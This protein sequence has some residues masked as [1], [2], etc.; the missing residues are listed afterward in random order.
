M[1]TR[2]TTSHWGAFE[3]RVKDGRIV[4]TAPFKDD[5][6]PPT[7][8]RT[9][10]QA[11]HH[12]TR[13]NRPHVR[14]GWLEKDR[15]KSRS[16]DTFIPM[17]WDEALDLAAQEIDRVRTQHG[18]T[19]I[20]GGSYG[21][22]SAGRFHHA[23][24]QVHRF[25][26]LLGG[27]VSSFAS[28]STGAAQTII[29]HILGTNF[30]K[31]T[32]G[33]QSTWDMIEAHT[34]TLLMFGGINPK[35]AQVSMGGVTEH[36]TASH[37][38]RFAA[39][40]K[41][42]IS[43]S[44]QR[45]DSPDCT[46]WLA[47]LPG[48][49]V[50]LMLALA[51]VLETDKLAD[52]SFLQSHCVGY[53]RFRPYLLGES[54]GEPKSPEWASGICGIGAAEIRALALRLTQGRTMISV[55]WSLQRA[56]HGEQ[57]YWMAC[58]L[59]AM[60]GQIGL[61]GGG[62]GFGYGAI[63]NV[64]SNVTRLRGPTLDQGSNAVE[65]FIPVSRIA[66]LLLNPNQPF[67]FNGKRRTYPDI[68]LVYWCGGNPFHHHQD[69]NRLM[70]AWDKPETIIVHEPW[71]TP[72][73]RR[74]DIV[75]PATTQFEREDI[76]WAKGDPYLFHMPKMIEPVAEARDDYAIFSGLAQRLELHEAFTEG[77]DATAWL[78]HLFDEFM[79]NAQT[80]GI[81][82]PDWATL[83][84]HNFIKLPIVPD[85]PAPAPFAAFRADPAQAPIGTPSGK[86]EVY[87]DTIAG[88]AYAGIKGHPTWLVP[89]CDTEYPLR[90]LSPQPKD[91]LHSQMQSALMDGTAGTLAELTLHP[92]DAEAR[93][94]VEGDLVRIWNAQGACLARL[95]VS[96]TIL[97]GVAA[98][99]TGAWFDPAPDGTDRAGNPNVLTRDCGTSLLGQG[100][101]AHNAGVE[102]EKA[103][104]SQATS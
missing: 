51:Y 100:A 39:Q 70:R 14:K 69:L 3:V 48:T 23:Q 45:S 95:T 74:A 2:I 61:P 41:R 75:F 87:S 37:L 65:E 25:L 93:G 43:V 99:P 10:P 30:H 49:D 40:G 24:S 90:L 103:N 56:Q 44:P 32:W 54:D 19:A 12:H 77:R 57:P 82:V 38:E 89:T 20:Y 21:W 35:N 66:D 13:I 26:N 17:D 4:G 81:A 8:F 59:A 47:L 28:Y 46:E 36:R 15:T 71:W 67:D 1:K 53:D 11:V 16:N 102:V 73:A 104:A 60:L 76:G 64:G 92:Q 88:F 78:A 86:I 68:R 80:D 7:I 63:G 31:V 27:Y 55:A 97:T 34:D 29:P 101:A 18:N 6:H 62:I 94:L 42:L 79:H 85:A 22:A 98:L 91:K 33:E 96:N 72:T 5:P 50:A 52:H 9:V 58:V 83:K 84:E